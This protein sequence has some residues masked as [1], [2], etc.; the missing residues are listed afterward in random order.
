MVEVLDQSEL[1][2]H[3]AR[4]GR[5]L[6]GGRALAA[7]QCGEPFSYARIH[8]G[9]GMTARQIRRPV[10]LD[11]IVNLLRG[12]IRVNIREQIDQMQTDEALQVFERNV[13]R[14]GRGSQHMLD[15]AADIL[16]TIEQGAVDIEQ[17][18]GEARDHAGW[19][20]S[21]SESPGKRR[22]G[23]GRS[24]CC[25]PSPVSLGGLAA[26][27]GSVSPLMICITSLPSRISR[28]RSAS[29]MRTSASE[30][31]SMIRTAVSYPPCT[32]FFTCASMRMAVSS[33]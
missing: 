23:S 18:D 4:G 6:G 12:I 9:L 8:S 25:V 30:C 26:I 32:N 20:R 11:Q 24:T 27:C 17:I 28:S 3:R 21:P 1:R 33:L 31:S 19:G 16:R 29:A 2:Q 22:L 5:S 7:A 14:G 13:L 10:L 15:G